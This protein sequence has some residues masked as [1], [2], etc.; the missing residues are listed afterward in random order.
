M[1]INP[2]NKVVV[3]LF[4]LS[5]TDI[6]F[7]TTATMSLEQWAFV[8][9][10]Y[11]NTDGTLFI[12]ID[13]HVTSVNAGVR[14]IDTTG[15]FYIGIFGGIPTHANPFRGKIR[16]LSILDGPITKDQISLFKQ[17][18]SEYLEGRSFVERPYGRIYQVNAKKSK[19]EI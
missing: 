1:F 18:T 15:D 8:G 17:R 4:D 10:S 13:D 12:W 2:S 5:L 6:W 14:D 11:N 3:N 9:A 7:Q 19:F 16:G